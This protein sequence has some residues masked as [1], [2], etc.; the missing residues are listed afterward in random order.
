MNSSIAKKSVKTKIKKK[1][2]KGIWMKN[3]LTRRILL[4]FNSVGSNAREN[5]LKKYS[6]A[7]GTDYLLCA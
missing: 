5:I 7:E 3:I 2:N 6:V 1:R 4:P